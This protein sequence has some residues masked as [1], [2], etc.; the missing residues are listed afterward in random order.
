NIL[1]NNIYTLFQ[2]SLNKR[3]R[4]ILPLQQWWG[5]TFLKEECIE[6][7]LRVLGIFFAAA[8]VVIKYVLI[9]GL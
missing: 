3:N 1:R 7:A 9:D 5:I 8:P 2:L 6:K 4:S